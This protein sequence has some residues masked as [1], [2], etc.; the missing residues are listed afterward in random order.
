M[1]K[2]LRRFGFLTLI[3]LFMVI[4]AACSSSGGSDGSETTYYDL[5]IAFD[6]PG[7][8][9]VV[10]DP[11]Q[12]QYK[13]GSVVSLTALPDAGASF[14]NWSGYLDSYNSNIQVNVNSNINIIAN[15]LEG[16]SLDLSSTGNGTTTISNFNSSDNLVT[17]F[18]P[19][20]DTGTTHTIGRFE[21]SNNI[22]SA[23]SNNS[24]KGMT[25]NSQYSI[26]S[27]HNFDSYLR[28]IERKTLREHNYGEIQYQQN[29]PKYAPQ[30]GDTESF[31][32]LVD[33]SATNFDAA[34]DSVEVKLQAIGD[35]TLVWLDSSVALTETIDINNLITQ[36]EDSIRP[37]DL[38][39]FGREPNASTFP[40]I[41]VN[42]E[43]INIVLA[44]MPDGVGGY[45]I[46]SDLYE[47]TNELPISNERKAFYVGYD[48]GDY[49]YTVLAHEFQHMI[50]YNEK[51]LSGTP[52]IDDTWLNEGFAML[53][54]D[55]TGYGYEQGNTSVTKLING[56]LLWPEETSL[57]VWGEI[58]QTDGNYAASYLFVRYLMDR[59]GED[60]ITY[61]NTSPKSPREDIEDYTGLSFRQL[62]EDWAL[63]VYFTG[64]G[65]G[66]S[67]YK[68]TSITL[69]EVYELDLLPNQY[70]ENINVKGWG[71]Y[72][73]NTNSGTGSDINLT[74]ENASTAGQ[75][76]MKSLKW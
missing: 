3:I 36:F 14:L 19:L 50:Y 35:N 6:G 64:K 23:V 28:D 27:K 42:G 62:F 37:T 54:Q 25:N 24:R 11:D 74:V 65:Q 4:F 10:K 21:V 44:D 12:E 9:S 43:K 59:Y 16:G 55:F 34:F 29:V 60:F 71:L 61:L 69:P 52:V 68:Y 39:Y 17:V 15:F 20:D 5:N 26:T 70:V 1:F 38:A 31:S 2:Y 73:F 30:V 63:A 7:T 67:K 75:F 53:A 45:F 48:Q 41:A 13:A 47:N 51:V 49:I 8:G 46:S 57:I 72:Y 56:Y 18:F 58:G 33:P 40:A 22:Q 66:F 32:V 76:R